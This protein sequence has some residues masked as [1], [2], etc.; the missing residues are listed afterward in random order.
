M[1]IVARALGHAL[2]KIFGPAAGNGCGN[3]GITNR[4][5]GIGGLGITWRQD[6]PQIELLFPRQEEAFNPI[7]TGKSGRLYRLQPMLRVDS[8]KSS[9]TIDSYFILTQDCPLPA[10]VVRGIAL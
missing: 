9:V 1:R 4:F 8:S 3:L 7:I 6:V 2:G 5:V 10:N